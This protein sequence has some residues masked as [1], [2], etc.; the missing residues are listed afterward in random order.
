MGRAALADPYCQE[1]IKVMH[2]A[3]RTACAVIGLFPLGIAAAN[4][5]PTAEA[6]PFA[7]F[8]GGAVIGYDNYRLN[9]EATLPDFGTPS[10][11]IGHM[12][13][14]G[15]SGGANIG[16]NFVLAPQLIAG[17]EGQ[18]RYSDAEGRTS[19][20]G[21]A[22][23]SDV[24]SK[25]RESWGLGARLGFLPMPNTM[26]YAAGGW[27]NTRFRTSVDDAA[28]ASLYRG[29]VRDDAWRVGG[30]VET[31]LG[32]KWTARVD[33]TYSNYSGY[34]VPVAAANHISVEPASHQVQV[35]VSRYF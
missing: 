15:V 31:A 6:N 27:T 19:T 20:A 16:Y 11:K 35:G 10:G 23:L 7:G 26:L 1:R 13:G 24:N 32:G 21:A 30:G 12:G 29:S 22:G 18:F 8:Y 4:A 2:Q 17:I 5:Q 3:L 25:T 28:G 33:Y 14:D 9:N 34:E